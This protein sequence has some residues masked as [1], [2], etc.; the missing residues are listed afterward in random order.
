MI[1]KAE[2]R[3]FRFFLDFPIQKVDDPI[4]TLT[5]ASFVWLVMWAVDLQVEGVDQVVGM[6]CL[7]SLGLIST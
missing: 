5:G 7:I 1:Q 3:A 2:G 4:Q 6:R